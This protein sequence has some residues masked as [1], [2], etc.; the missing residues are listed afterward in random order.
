MLGNIDFLE[1][2]ILNE[3]GSTLFQSTSLPEIV[4]MAGRILKLTELL[5]ERKIK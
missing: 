2:Q 1:F 4:V 3:N 5:T